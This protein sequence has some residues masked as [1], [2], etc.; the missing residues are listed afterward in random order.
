MSL[1]ALKDDYEQK[2][3]IFTAANKTYNRALAAADGAA[4]ADVKEAFFAM[5]QAKD[6][7]DA[8]YRAIVAAEIGEAS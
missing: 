2:S 7:M 3:A 4:S 5:H 8:A 1:A 6:Q